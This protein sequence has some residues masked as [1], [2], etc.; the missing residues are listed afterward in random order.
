MVVEL[1]IFCQ[2]YQAEGSC[3]HLAPEMGVPQEERDKA[4]LDC[5]TDWDA[6]RVFIHVASRGSFRST[7][8]QLEFS[9]DGIRK[10]IDDFQIG[11]APPRACQENDTFLVASTIRYL[12]FLIPASTATRVRHMVDGLVEAFQFRKIPVVQGR[13]HPST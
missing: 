12:A 2:I 9:I 10:R 3:M 5:L 6:A 1:A 11:V 4:V 13:I 7:A 8:E